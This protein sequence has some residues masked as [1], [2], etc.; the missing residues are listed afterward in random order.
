M[1]TG[2]KLACRYEDG[3]LVVPLTCEPLWGR[4]VAVLPTAPARVTLKTRRGSYAQG[5]AV[6]YEITLCDRAGEVMEV[7]LP[8]EVRIIDAEK[9]ERREYGGVRVLDKGRFAKTIVLAEK[10]PLGDWEITITER[11]S[12]HTAHKTIGVHGKQPGAPE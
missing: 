11:L 12:R 2:A 7:K 9:R 5:E 3:A 1:L 10:E 4:V 8:V 6:S